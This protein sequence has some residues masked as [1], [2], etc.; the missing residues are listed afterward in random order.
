MNTGLVSVPELFGSSGFN[1]SADGSLAKTL[2]Q[3][4]TL[5]SSYMRVYGFRFQPKLHITA[6]DRM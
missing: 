6:K 1:F 5:Y 4:P 2:D 3:N